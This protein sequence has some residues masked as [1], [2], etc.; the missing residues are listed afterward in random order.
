[1][2]AR[3]FCGGTAAVAAIL[4]SLVIGTMTEAASRQPV[5]KVNGAANPPVGHIVFC[6]EDPVECLPR[7]AGLGLELTAPL[8]QQLNAVNLRINREVI[9][10]TDKDLYSVEEVWALPGSYG[11]CEDYALLKRSR[12]V[13][14]GWPTSALLVT[15]VFDEVG[16]GHAVLLAHTLQGDFVL[17]NKTD[18]IRRWYETPYQFVKRQAENDPKQWVSIG[19]PRWTTRATAAAR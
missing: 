17:D 14:A 11:D 1:M 16:D 18:E 5:L 19:D 4:G 7:G 3:R 13:A 2:L 9:P 15:V 12:L 10:V 8:W 6:A